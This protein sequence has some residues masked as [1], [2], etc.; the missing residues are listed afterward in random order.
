MPEVGCV[1]YLFEFMFKREIRPETQH[2]S[3]GMKVEVFDDEGKNIEHTGIAGEMV[4]RLSQTSL[5]R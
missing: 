5:E 1:L 3:L 4:G 2:K